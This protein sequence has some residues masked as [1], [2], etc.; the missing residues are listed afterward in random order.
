ME[1]ELE[2]VKKFLKYYVS[3]TEVSSTD[4]IIYVLL[5]EQPALYKKAL[6]ATYPHTTD[7]PGKDA[8]ERLRDFIRLNGEELHKNDLGIDVEQI[9]YNTVFMTLFF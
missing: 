1:N 7:T 8:I 6:K 4:R 9:D 5:V 3:K 2:N